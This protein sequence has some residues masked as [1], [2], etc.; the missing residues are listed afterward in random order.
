M[1]LY[2]ITN[3]A[4]LASTFRQ[5]TEILCRLAAEWAGGG[6]DYLQI[7]E[8]DLDP[9]DLEQLSRKLVEGVRGS[10]TR[11]L[12]N[13]RADIAIAVGADGV[14]L[15]GGEQLTTAELRDLFDRAGRPE[16]MVSI[17]CHTSAE[18]LAAKAAGVSAILY[19][20]VFGKRIEGGEMQGVGLPAL[21]QAC[22]V[23]S[24]VPLFALGGVTKENAKECIAAGATGVAAIRLFASGEWKTLRA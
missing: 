1:Q 8:K 12:I 6:V 23:A 19:A 15:P 10:H 2:A 20:P 9:G 22:A 21:S 4:E 14:H 24:P 3:S 16:P 11:V 17:S 7:R 5:R 13:G 18:V